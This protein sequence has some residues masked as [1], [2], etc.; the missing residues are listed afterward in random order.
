VTAGGRSAKFPL[1]LS[2]ATEQVLATGV[3]AGLGLI[4]DAALT[5]VYLPKGPELVLKQASATSTSESEAKLKLV[6]QA[7]SGV[8]L[9]AAAEAMSL[10]SNV[11]LDTKKL[12]E[13]ISTAAGTSW[14]FVDRVPQL[15]SGKWSKKKSVDDV[16]AELVCDGVSCFEVQMVW[17]RVC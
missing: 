5:A 12:Y 1:F 8:H 9:V 6:I 10:G 11:G 16:I 13:I 15:L 7:M 3:S 17:K 2:S 4:D 14:M